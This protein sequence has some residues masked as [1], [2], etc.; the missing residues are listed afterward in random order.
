M[1]CCSSREDDVVDVDIDDIHGLA[2]AT[3]TDGGIGIGDV[4]HGIGDVPRSSLS[5][6]FQR[7]TRWYKPLGLQ[8]A[9]VD[10]IA[11][12]TGTLKC[13]TF[14]GSSSSSKS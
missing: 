9:L 4:P 3:L 11:T 10:D 13:V 7:A 5:L 12:L 1:P 2:A 14:S 6:S 8:V